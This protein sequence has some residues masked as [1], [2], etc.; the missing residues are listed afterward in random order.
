MR[1][2]ILRHLALAATLVAVAG[3]GK[4]ADTTTPL[5]FVPADTPYL[6]AN[7]E[8]APDS[9]IAHW[10]EQMQGAWPLFT[11]MM[12]EMLAQVG[13]TD[14]DSA[15]PK[16]LKAVLDEMRGRSTP[17]QWREIGFDPK[18]HA[19]FYGV[20]LLPVMRLELADPDA[21]RAMIARIE[22]KS[23]TALGTTRI[24]E[25]DVRTF[26]NDEARGLVAIEGKHLVVAFAAGGADE[27]LERKLLG[28]DR[29]AQVLDASALAD[30]NK[31]R[32]YLPYGSGWVDTRR[33]V[34]MIAAKA[35]AGDP[36]KAP[37][38]TC[39]DEID[40]LAAKA[41]R[42]AIGYR[43]LDDKRM[44]MHARIELDPVLAKSLSALAAPLPGSTPDDALLDFALAAP[45]LKARDF[46]VAQA[47]AVTKA[48]FRCAELASINQSMAEAKAKLA[49]T[50]PPPFGDLSG[51]RVTLSRFA[52]PAGE[53][54]MPDVAGTFL[55]GSSNPALLASLAQM[56]SP[57]LAGIAIAP[58]GKPVAIPSAALPP[59][60]AGKL[61]LDVA[62]T[63]SAIGVSFGKDE[64][65]RLA[66]AI[67]APAAADGTLFTMRLRGEMYAKFADA[68]D[69]FSASLPPE[70][71]KQLDTQRKLYALYAQWFDHI[72]ARMAL[73]PEGVD[74][75]ESVTFGAH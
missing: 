57:A 28:I 48:P 41:P 66:A 2:R 72:D 50:I 47:D 67:A 40:A 52:W 25:Q 16:V 38:A 75:S 65:Q 35:A 7:I 1:T 58:D 44:T 34:A 61:D 20:D 63:T 31:A 33:L 64:A 42:L 68:M 70:S 39:R 6:F 4:K 13:K 10:R 73:V 11:D 62:M 18:A 12:D 56:T 45:V 69:R 9:A 46:L 54:S 29:P 24:G 27:A 15:A 74:F 8:P 14:A 19:A 17:E 23:G 71:R 55:L 22:Q 51:A 43:D 30:F 21:F 53:A 36:A 3:C 59:Q 37:D 5:A 49:Q 60:L 32:G 26:G